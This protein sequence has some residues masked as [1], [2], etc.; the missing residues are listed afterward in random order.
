MVKNI[1]KRAGSVKGALVKGYLERV[2]R[3]AFEYLFKD[4]KKL[5][6]DSSGIYGLYNGDKLYYVGISERLLDRVDWHTQ[7][8]H[9]YSWDNVSF[10]IIDKHNF[11]KDIETLILRLLPK[12]PK[13]NGT[14]G[15]FEE[16]YKMTDQLL[17]KRRELKDMAKRL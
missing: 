6:G 11:S 13:G 4:F 7:D 12:S 8:K 15:K 16:H 10:F 14:R 17:K 9:Q 1:R 2:D 5:L 3:K